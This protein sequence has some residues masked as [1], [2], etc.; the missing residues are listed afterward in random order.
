MYRLTKQYREC[1]WQFVC[2]NYAASCL[3]SLCSFYTKLQIVYSVK[4]EERE[5]AFRKS[6]FFKSRKIFL[7]GKMYSYLEFI[8]KKC[9][10]T[11][12]TVIYYTYSLNI[13]FVA[14]H[15]MVINMPRSN[16]YSELHSGVLL[17]GSIPLL[18][19]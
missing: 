19:T 8:P 14:S 9:Q 12:Q 13:I 15:W 18:H 16:E 4:L 11:S 17:S 1:F 10:F 2:F 5:V 3:S 6:G 7:T